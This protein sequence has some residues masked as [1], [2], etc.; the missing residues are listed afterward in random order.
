ML[1]RQEYQLTPNITVICD[2]KGPIGLAGIKGGAE[3]SVNDNTKTIVLES[4]AF[5]RREKILWYMK[6]CIQAMR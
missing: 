2:A 3:Y 4:A 5:K 1:M 6:S